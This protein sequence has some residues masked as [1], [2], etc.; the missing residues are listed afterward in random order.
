MPQRKNEATSL[1]G[2]LIIDKPAGWTSHDV[3]ARVRRLIGER[4]VGHA[5]TLDPAATG[6]LPIA[7]GHA[8][9]SL[10][11]LSGASKTYRAEITF[12]VE[13]DSY[14]ADGQVTQQ[15][16]A[17]H[18]TASEVEA[19]LTAFRGQIE[20]IPPMHSALKI[21]GK[22]LYELA[23]AGETVERA[24]RAV[25]IYS[26]ILMNWSSP[27]ATVAIDCSKGTYVRSLA[28]DVGKRTGTGAYLSDLVRLRT[29]PFFLC[30]ALTL[31]DLEERDV[32]MAWS[33][34]AIH[35]DAAV[36]DLPVLLLDEDATTRWDSGRS[37]AGRPHQDGR[38]RVYNAQGD[39]AG[40]AAFDT[41]SSQWRPQKVIVSA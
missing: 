16:D 23:R 32:R 2:F 38:A 29:G 1:H 26:L 18:L 6:V 9:K 13:T 11:Y 28:R 34:V 4:H 5:G 21:G 17:Y 25:E 14:D 41:V 40:I 3:V 35:P 36:L 7:I 20:Q 12:G 37:I 27:T 31:G 22:K 8:T 24:A 39:W 15:R 19:A 10:E 30:E 33:D